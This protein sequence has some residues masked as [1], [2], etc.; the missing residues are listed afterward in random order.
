MKENAIVKRQKML[1]KR[2]TLA[3]YLSHLG[4]VEGKHS[5]SPKEYGSPLAASLRAAIVIVML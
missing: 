5:L 1:A 2:G 4:V 3:R